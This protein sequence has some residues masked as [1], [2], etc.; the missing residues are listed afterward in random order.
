MKSCGILKIVK[1]M[2]NYKKTFQDYV[3]PKCKASLLNIDKALK[4]NRCN[5]SFPIVNSIPDFYIG[6]STKEESPVIKSVGF[7]D[8]LSNIYE[9]PFWYPLVYHI[10]GGINIPKISKTIHIITEMINGNGGLILDVACGTGLYTRSLA[11]GAEKVIGTDISFGMLQRAKRLAKKQQIP[12]IY[13]NRAG[14]KRMPFKDNFFD[15]IACCGALHLFQ[16][17]YHSLMEIARVLKSKGTFAVMI[18]IRRRFLKYP[19][20]YQHLKQEHG[21]NI[22]RLKELQL[23]LKKAGFYE[24]IPKIYGSMILFSARKL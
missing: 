22:F 16:D 2:K 12:N 8:I 3:C 15:G 18:F 20:V 11:K 24:F 13:F 10:Y 1:I 5:V 19:W 14:V 23:L 6:D 4:C 7:I 17:I 9:S 21:A